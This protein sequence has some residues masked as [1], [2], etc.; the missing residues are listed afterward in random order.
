MMV[1][2][3]TVRCKRLQT[4]RSAVCASQQFQRARPVNGTASDAHPEFAVWT[5]SG[6]AVIAPVLAEAEEPSVGGYAPVHPP[7]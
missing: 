1:G 2:C 4:D 5:A 7:R 6:G 3:R